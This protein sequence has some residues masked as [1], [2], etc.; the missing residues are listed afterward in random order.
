M[1]S[2]IEYISEINTYVS[3][4]DIDWDDW[5]NEERFDYNYP[6]NYQI[7]N[8]I[9]EEFDFDSFIVLAPVYGLVDISLS[10]DRL[11]L[12]INDIDKHFSDNGFNYDD[13]YWDGLNLKVVN[14]GVIQLI[15]RDKLTDYVESLDLHNIPGFNKRKIGN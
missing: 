1:K 8:F 9:D 10:D 14:N 5:D 12:E 2:Y 6:T 15:G 11:N 3:K 4:G 13:L 7:I